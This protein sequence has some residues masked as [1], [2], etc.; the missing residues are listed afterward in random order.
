MEVWRVC[1]AYNPCVRVQIAPL[2]LSAVIWL[3]NILVIMN[4]ILR[5]SMA[6]ATYVCSINL[7]SDLT[8]YWLPPWLYLSYPWQIRKYRKKHEIETCKKRHHWLPSGLSRADNG[9]ATK[10]FPE[11]AKLESTDKNKKEETC[12][13]RPHWLPSWLRYNTQWQWQCYKALHSH[14]NK[15]KYSNSILHSNSIFIA[16]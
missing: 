10:P 9:N 11:M 4:A 15:P 5:L 1:L 7:C 3:L 2:I 6:G 8:S 14:G 12:K 13:K 16:N